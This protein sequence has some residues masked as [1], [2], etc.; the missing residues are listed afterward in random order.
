M[1]KI[2]LIGI[3]QFFDGFIGSGYLLG[4]HFFFL[5]GRI[6]MLNLL[7]PSLNF[8]TDE[9]RIFQQL[10][11]PAPDNFIEVILAHWAVTAHSPGWVTII[12]RA[13]AAVIIELP[14]GCAGRSTV[15][16]MPTFTAD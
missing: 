13:Q 4:K 15:K 8:S 3:Q 16:G 2:F 11:H 5:S 7:Q 12:I 14:F 9:F 1:K 6:R 10:E